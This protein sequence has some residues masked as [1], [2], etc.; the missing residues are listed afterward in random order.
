MSILWAGD[1]AWKGYFSIST[2]RTM[3]LTMFMIIQTSIK[4]WRS[5]ILNIRGKIC[6]FIPAENCVYL[7]KIS[8]QVGRRQVPEEARMC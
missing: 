1:S 3:Y 7:K 4:F 5:V 6:N 2:V 8:R